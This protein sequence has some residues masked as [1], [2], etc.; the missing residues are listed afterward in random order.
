MKNDLFLRNGSLH[1]T[2]VNWNQ[3]ILYVDKDHWKQLA[4]HLTGLVE[5]SSVFIL[6]THWWFNAGLT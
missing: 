2:I 1:L 5:T 6:F 4:S 3:S